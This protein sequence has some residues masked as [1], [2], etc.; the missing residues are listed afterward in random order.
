MKVPSGQIMLREEEGKNV[1]SK[2]KKLKPKPKE[3]TEMNLAGETKEGLDD[4]AE[5]GR[6]TNKYGHLK[7]ESEVLSQCA[8]FDTAWPFKDQSLRPMGVTSL[9]SP[10]G[11]AQRD[12]KAFLGS[13]CKC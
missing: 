3:S 9:P 12:D 1:N 10:Q 6:G 13:G 5:Y 2:N 4:M 7:G 8:L 11:E